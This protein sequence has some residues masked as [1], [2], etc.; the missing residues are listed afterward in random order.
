MNLP[1]RGD[2][3]PT[4]PKKGKSQPVR[5][6]LDSFANRI[7]CN[8]PF[9]R[10]VASHPL[11][12]TRGQKA[13]PQVNHLW[14][15]GK[16]PLPPFWLQHQLF[17]RLRNAT[18]FS[19]GDLFVISQTIPGVAVLGGTGGVKIGTVFLKKLGSDLVVQSSR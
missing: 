19:G 8:F 17:P 13:R 4:Y 12:Q 10:K 18:R 15:Y 14:K 3:R 9:F 6:V 7:Y 2:R 16:H 1:P 5:F 11:I